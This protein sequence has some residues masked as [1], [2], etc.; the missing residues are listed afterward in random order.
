MKAEG[1]KIACI[2]AYDASFATLVDDAGVDLVLVGDSLGM[3][4][5]GHDTTVPVTLEDIIYHCRAVAEGPVPPVPDGRHA[6]HDLR[7]ARSR[8]SRTPCA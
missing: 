5:Q 8:R 1:E 6:V 4:I 3:V 7:L 2:T